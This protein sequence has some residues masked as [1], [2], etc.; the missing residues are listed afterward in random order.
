MTTEDSERLKRIEQ[1][2]I[3]DE[4]MGHIGIVSRLKDVED[5]IEKDKGLKKKVT[6]G[7]LV[8]SFVGSVVV[9]GLMWLLNKIWP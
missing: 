2:L 7:I 4:A 5:Y 8:L 1:A 9:S 3:G 6:G